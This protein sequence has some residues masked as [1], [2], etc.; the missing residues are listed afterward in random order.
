MLN[1][2]TNKF[3]ALQKVFETFETCDF[4]LIRNGK[5]NHLVNTN[6]ISVDLTMIFGNEF[7]LD[8]INPKKYI[9]LFKIMSKK[10]IK[11]IDEYDMRRFVILNDDI[12][13]FFPKKHISSDL[14]T[15]NITSLIP[16]GNRVHIKDNKKTIKNLIGSNIAKLLI[17][18]NQFKGILV[19]ETGIYKFPEYINDDIKEDNCEILNSYGFLGIDSSEYHIQLGKDNRNS[20]WIYTVINFET[21]IDV[22]ILENVNKKNLDNMLI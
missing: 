8:V 18:E 11:L 10:N 16:V 21:N 17:H 14:I 22:T 20:Y 13:L 3:D 6:I 1:L 12:K 7:N 19:E 5:I 9:K 4:I 15:D 2:D